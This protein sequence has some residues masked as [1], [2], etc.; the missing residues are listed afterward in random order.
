MDQFPE[1]F[2]MADYFLYHNLEEGRENKVSLYYQDQTYTYGE[3]ARMSNRVGNALRE[4]GVEIEERVLI[5]LPDCPEFVWTWFGSARI[6]AVI[7]MVNPLLPAEDYRYY[8]EYTRAR[9]AVIHESLLETF[10]SAAEGA[11]YLRAVLV[12]GH[13]GVTQ[14]V[15]LS[16]AFRVTDNQNSAQ[17]TS[18]F[19][20]STKSLQLRL[21]NHGHAGARILQVISVVLGRQQRI[22]HSNY[23]S[24][25]RRS[26]PCPNKLRTVR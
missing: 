21:V 1:R 22:D 2:N 17:I 26:K 14:T 23:R 4:L 11:R 8:L 12:V 13:Q 16:Y 19:S 24:D 3:I 6:G 10:I 25:T 9:V 20:S 5:V 7:T 15:S 18:A